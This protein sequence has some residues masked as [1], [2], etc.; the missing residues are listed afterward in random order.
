MSE[1]RLTK[2]YEPSA[3]RRG[4]LATNPT[5]FV[6]TPS[7]ERWRFARKR[8]ATR[9]IAGG[10][11]C[12]EHERFL[13][14]HCRGQ[15]VSPPPTKYQ[16]PAP[17]ATPLYP[18]HWDE[19]GGDPTCEHERIYLGERRLTANPGWYFVCA[20]C[21]QTGFTSFEDP[22]FV[23]PIDRARGARILFDMTGDSYWQ[24]E[25]WKREARKV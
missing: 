15:K 4:R 21:L 16:R 7:G 18:M 6:D 9:F 11:V 3:I 19:R 22:K 1:A 8:D 5:W 20:K 12:P 23:P 17:D 25:A 10:C 2:V 24:K 13:C 14:K